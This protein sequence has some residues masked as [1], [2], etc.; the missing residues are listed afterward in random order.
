MQ[1]GLEWVGFRNLEGHSRQIQITEP[2]KD[3]ALQRSDLM[4]D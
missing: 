1:P 3:G 4:D 2:T